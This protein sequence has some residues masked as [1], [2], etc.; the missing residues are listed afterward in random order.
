MLFTFSLAQAR[1][2]D[3]TCYDGSR[4][5]LP[6]C[7]QT[8]PNHERKFGG[9]RRLDGGWQLSLRPSHATNALDWCNCT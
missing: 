9:A 3:P 8:I 5:F 2:L 1:D 4:F 7:Y 6:H